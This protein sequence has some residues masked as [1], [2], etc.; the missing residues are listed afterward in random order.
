MSRHWNP[1]IGGNEHRR[2]GGW[3]DNCGSYIRGYQ[4][5]NVISPL[6]RIQIWRKDGMDR[7]TDMR[8]L[9]PLVLQTLRRALVPGPYLIFLLEQG[10]HLGK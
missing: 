1:G 6:Q 9:G 10:N 3:A 8:G 5:S 7:N 4:V 2:F